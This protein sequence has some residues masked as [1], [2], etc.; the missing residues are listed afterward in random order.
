MSYTPNTVVISGYRVLRKLWRIGF[1][2]CENNYQADPNIPEDWEDLFID[3][4][5][6]YHNANETFFGAIIHKSSADSPTAEFDLILADSNTISS[7]IETFHYIFD[8]IY[9]NE[10]I[11]L[12]TYSKYLGVKWY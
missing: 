11:P 6:N 8:K 1:D 12:P 3:M 5:Y 4:D 7:I 10:K 9:E 2:Y